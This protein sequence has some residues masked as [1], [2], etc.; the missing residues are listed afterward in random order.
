MHRT[1]N[2]VTAQCAC[3]HRD[4]SGLERF[5]SVTSSYYRGSH[6]RLMT[7]TRTHTCT[8]TRTHTHVHTHAHTM[9]VWLILLHSCVCKRQWNTSSLSLQSH[10]WRILSIFTA[11]CL[12]CVQLLC[13]DHIQPLGPV[14]G[15]IKGGKTCAQTCVCMEYSGV[16]KLSLVIASISKYCLTV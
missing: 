12:D 13:N 8:H 10:R 2:C 1:C 11:G 5:R 6:V 3:T 14:V 16:Y 15:G 9:C 7:H 4:T